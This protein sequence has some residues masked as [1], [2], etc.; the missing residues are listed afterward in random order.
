[1]S[2]LGTWMWFSGRE[3]AVEPYCPGSSPAQTGRPYFFTGKTGRPM[4]HLAFFPRGGWVG[5]FLRH[6]PN[7]RGGVVFGFFSGPGGWASSFCR[8][9]PGGRGWAPGHARPCRR[10]CSPLH[11][12]QSSDF[13]LDLLG[14]HGATSG[15][16]QQDYFDAMIYA[17]D[18][19]N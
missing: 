7:G 11:I 10:S 18:V 15:L 12:L 13:G 3:S 4:S 14:W 16:N 19:Y 6:M 9:K 8:Q 5:V 1:M 2:F 17:V